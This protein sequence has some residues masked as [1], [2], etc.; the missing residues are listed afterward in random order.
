MLP[1]NL[2][3][4]AYDVL[5][6]Y[7]YQFFSSLSLIQESLP[8]PPAVFF[9]GKLKGLPEFGVWSVLQ[10]WFLCLVRIVAQSGCSGSSCGFS[11]LLALQQC[12]A[13]S[14]SAAYAAAAL[15]HQPV[16]WGGL[17]FC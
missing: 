10:H 13:S 8:R 14:L 5:P 16:R 4:T 12:Y 6:N 9:V 7:G 11:C 17:N 3:F 15:L 1:I 2:C